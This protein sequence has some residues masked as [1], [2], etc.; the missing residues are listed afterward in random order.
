MST[1]KLSFQRVQILSYVV[2]KH[3]EDQVFRR[4]SY[5]TVL[6]IQS[7]H[8]SDCTK[9]ILL[10]SFANKINMK[11]AWFSITSSNESQPIT[12]LL[13]YLWILGTRTNPCSLTT[14]VCWSQWL[15]ITESVATSWN[16]YLHTLWSF[17]YLAVH[18]I[19]FI[20]FK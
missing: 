8:G 1:I 2:I 15:R 4:R 11:W 6:D 17:L 10:Q 13:I 7:L 20:S 14:L 18:G 3:H 16:S 19:S 5:P 9:Y 12:K